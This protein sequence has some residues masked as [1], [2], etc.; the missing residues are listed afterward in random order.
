MAQTLLASGSFLKEEYLNTLIL[1]ALKWTF[2]SFP[3]VFF[4]EANL[5]V[6]SFTLPWISGAGGFTYGV[7]ST[8]D[9]DCKLQGVRQFSLPAA[10]G[11][12]SVADYSWAIPSPHILFLKYPLLLAFVCGW[13]GHR[14]VSRIPWHWKVWLFPLFL[15]NFL[16]WRFRFCW[17]VVL[18]KLFLVVISWK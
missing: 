7:H 10:H 12:L 17:D 15:G 5:Q 14:R 3:Q 6:S 16:S 13:F 4:K 9:K 2:F 8:W 1:W 18:Q 11:N